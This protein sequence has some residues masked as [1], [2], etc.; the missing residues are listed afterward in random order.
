MSSTSSILT[1]R[2]F[3]TWQPNLSK[4]I[5]SSVWFVRSI[6]RHTC[7]SGDGYN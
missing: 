3:N 5:M 4:G 2:T 1:L 7:D 6:R